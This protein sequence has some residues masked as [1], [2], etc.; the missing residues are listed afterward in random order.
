MFAGLC[1]KM[2]DYLESIRPSPVLYASRISVGMQQP[3]SRSHSIVCCC[4]LG[5]LFWISRT[6][7]SIPC[8]RFAFSP[9]GP[10]STS[11]ITLFKR[12]SSTPFVFAND[13]K[14]NCSCTWPV[15]FILLS[16]ESCRSLGYPPPVG[17]HLLLP[18]CKP[19]ACFL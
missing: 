17:R 3:Q 15:L 18:K 1:C 13:H 4:Q 11:G 9:S 6:K 8:S 16:S 19:E 5:H 12:V 10:T 2:M 14:A 7:R